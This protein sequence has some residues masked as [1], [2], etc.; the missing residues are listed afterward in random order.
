[1]LNP[2]ITYNLPCPPRTLPIA[3]PAYLKCAFQFCLA[4]PMV[5]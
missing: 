5:L 4:T 1:M 3:L 2:L